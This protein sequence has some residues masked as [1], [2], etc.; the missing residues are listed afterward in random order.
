MSLQQSSTHCT[1]SRP[2]TEGGILKLTQKSILLF[3]LPL[4]VTWLMMSV[5]GPFLAAIIARLADAKFNLA[6]Y[7]VAF[8][9]ALLVEA[10]VIMIM[11]ASTALADNATSFRRLRNF[12][13]AL[14]ATVTVAM[15]FMLIPPV[16]ESVMQGV[17]GLPR[18]VMDL[19]YVSLWLFLPWPGAIGYRRFYQGLLIRD[20]RTRLVAYGTVVRLTSMAAT[21]LLLYATVAPPGAYV[22]AAAM[23]V[24]VTLEA[25]ASR[26]MARAS[27]RQLLLTPPAD[28]GAKQ[29]GY[30]GIARFYY[31]LALTSLIGLAMQPMLT[32]FMGRAPSPIE[33]LAVFPVVH[34]L[35]FIFRAM[36][37]SYQEVAIALMGPNYE[38]VRELGRFA[39]MLGIASSA[40]LAVVALTPAAVFWFET[41]SGLSPE[42]ASFAI[43]P[44]IILVPVPLLAVILSYQRGIM[45]NAHVTRPVTWATVIEVAVVAVGF[46]ILAWGIGMVG[47]TAAVVS[48]LVGR[49]AG[50]A[51]LIRPCAKVVSWSRLAKPGTLQSESAVARRDHEPAV[52]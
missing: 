36:G 44:T 1:F 3:W 18:Q 37:L 45:V 27:V 42:L 13:Y 9:F 22:G 28:G 34:A 49:L 20:R 12:T 48:F 26:L 15:L 40:G 38:H 16:F 6:A 17:L 8:A 39:W 2:L 41:A 19:S 24:G 7:G 5:E 11:S 47:V 33:S 32:F 29:L 50:N 10:P 35:S 21:G 30:R 14:N 43:L 52:T 46:P 25:V 31:P 51:F 4:A 23:S